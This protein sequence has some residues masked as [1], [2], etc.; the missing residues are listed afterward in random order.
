MVPAA[1]AKAQELSQ[2]LNSRNVETWSISAWETQ[3]A[4]ALLDGTDLVITTGGDGTI[5][6]AALVTSGTGVPVLGVNMGTLGFLTEIKIAEA[7]SQL[8]RVL[9]GQGWLDERSVLEAELQS[10][11]QDA[12]L[13]KTYY[14]LNDV[15]MARGSI[16]RLIK[17]ATSVNGQPMT[18]YRA[19]GVIVSTATGSTGYS[20][21]AGGPVLYPQSKDILVVPI[22]SHLGLNYPLVLPPESII[23]LSLVTNIPATLSI[24]GYENIPLSDGCYVTLKS[25]SRKVRFLRLRPQNHFFNMLEEK[26]KGKN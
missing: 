2:F 12:R 22:L 26:L 18:N 6:R 24:D 19:D 14:A 5:L 21:S 1:Q 25:S 3:K 23:K 10:C 11:G 16:A 13:Q 4:I 8:S 17:I 9:E 7:E 20:L 15:V